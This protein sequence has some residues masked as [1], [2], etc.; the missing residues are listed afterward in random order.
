MDSAHGAS[1]EPRAPV[2]ERAVTAG[3][4][5]CGRS[6]VA[7][8]AT[9]A[10]D[11]M[12]LVAT[13]YTAAELAMDTL[14]CVL[15]GRLVE[16][17]VEHV[18]HTCAAYPRLSYSVHAPAVLDLRDQQHPA[19]HR[20]I[21]RSSVRFAG[22]IGA[23]VLVVHF[24]AH[25][26]RRRVEEAY[27]TAI[28]EAAD[29]AGRHEVILGIENIEVERTE[30]VVEFVEALQHPW[31]RMTYDFA[32]DYLAADYFGYDHI[33]SACACASYAAHL[34]LTDNFGRFNLARLDDFAIYRATPH[35]NVAIMGL[36][37][38]HL[39]L[40]WGSLPARD[41][42]RCFAE[43]GYTGLLISEHDRGVYAHA[44]EQVC[45]DLLALTT[46]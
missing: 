23:R 35:A 7:G 31:V 12:H 4:V 9:L 21:L 11:L 19:I 30:R 18:A 40:G 34:H 17:T 13:G 15:G 22:A 41:V 39:P 20:A 28:D 27:R 3:A 32:H 10:D 24:E 36:G 5:Q 25:S 33:A 16:R 42:Y 1:G 14:Q 46:R 26:D 6:V 29:L 43:R 37:D 8:P 45:R 38:L 44:D 2:P